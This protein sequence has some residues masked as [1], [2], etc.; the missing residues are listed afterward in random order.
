MEDEAE[1]LIGDFNPNDRQ[2]VAALK[3][4]AKAFVNVVYNSCPNGRRRAIA[5]T[6]IEEAAMMAVKSLY[7]Q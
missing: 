2:D 5:L 6:H 7:E 3:H 1:K 4:A